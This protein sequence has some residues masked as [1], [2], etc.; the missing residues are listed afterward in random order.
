MVTIDGST[1]RCFRMCRSIV[2]LLP[3]LFVFG[4]ASVDAPLATDLRSEAGDVHS[5]ARWFADLDAAID[6]A[7]VRDAGAYRI[8]G[9]PYL[10]VD[11]F[12][13]SFASAA[14]ASDAAFAA[15]MVRLEALDRTA[16]RVEIV[17]LPD[18]A[19]TIGIADAADIERLT[20]QCSET[21]RTRDLAS[22][23]ARSQLVAR[24]K[25]PDDYEDWERAIGLYPLVSIPFSAGI[26]A[27]Q[28]A[29]SAEFQE[30]DGHPL[31][32]TSVRYAPA[33]SSTDAATVA[34]LVKQAPRDAFGIPQ[35]S[36]LDRATLLATFA[37]V[38]RVVTAGPYDRIGALVWHGG[39]TPSVDTGRPI[40]YQD[41]VFTRFNGE[42]VIQ[43]VYTV[44]FPER[45]LAGP[46]DTLGGD[47]D[48]IVF[49]V[50]LD[51][52]G[53]PLIYDSIHPCGCYH[54]FFP[55]QR[56]VARP[57]LEGQR[58]WAFA[59]T[60]APDVAPPQ[61][62]VVTADTATHYLAGVEI[63]D[64]GLSTTYMRV[65]YDTL[66]SLPRRNGS[67]SAF[68][69]DGI[70]PG[71]ERAER[72][73]FWPMGIESAGAMRQWGHHAT[74][75]VGRRFFDSP[76]L[77]DQRF[78][79]VADHAVPFDQSH[80]AWQQLLHRSVVV[81]ADGTRSAVDYA[82]LKADPP[83]LDAY[84]ASLSAVSEATFARWS[85]DER[86]AFL[87]N[88]YNAFTIELILT[89]YPDL[90]SIRDLGS[91]FGTPWQEPFF[92]LLG[93][94]RSLDDVEHGLIRKPGAFDD[95]RVHF[96]LVCASIGCPM[97]RNEAYVGDR[98]DAQLDD[99]MRRFLADRTRNRYDPAGRTL[100]VSR[101]FDWYGSDFSQGY[102]GFT[103]V[104]ATLALFAGE[105]ADDPADQA[106]IR[107]E[108]VP[109]SFLDYDWRLNDL[110][111]LPVDA[112]A[113]PM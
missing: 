19:G 79:L 14:T 112:G 100:E 11:R 96:A 80:A 6:Q 8:P 29:T 111:S 43:L 10:R 22:P 42:V 28:T 110:S 49:R 1:T 91:T 56:L 30:I 33:A 9:F 55:T 16:R 83:A 81:S 104:P 86:L 102:Q 89:R 13:A 54:M 71:T 87:I 105:L 77:I 85:R 88:A 20:A 3:V 34:S 61:R 51:D 32:A 99:A 15:W 109:V 46:F 67:R 24:A 18:K 53:Q 38:F 103:S 12:T 106:A 84:L 59:P 108:Q 60:T 47:L 4:C 94:R 107:A 65:D 27:W 45:P 93:S 23:A 39:E 98:L 68:G 50:T 92:T 75:F 7:G 76:D 64:G 52:Q 26:D 90:T 63:D 5:C 62:I 95:P 101:I 2:L 97:L 35:L 48:G 78:Q 70:I 25:V 113:N 36:E 69:P 82:A 40:V 37:P 58:E 66:R 17:N 72:R 41:L 73:L 31:A 44:W 57:A 21:L 74:A